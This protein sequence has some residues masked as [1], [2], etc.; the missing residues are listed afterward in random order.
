MK[1]SDLNHF[2]TSHLEQNLCRIKMVGIVKTMCHRNRFLN[3]ES[4]PIYQVDKEPKERES[5]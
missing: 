3:V 5:M 4:W 1:M 2:V